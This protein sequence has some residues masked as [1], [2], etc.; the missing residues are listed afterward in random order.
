MINI[1]VTLEHFLRKKMFVCFVCT[2]L[3][4]G[5]TKINYFFHTLGL[6]TLWYRW[7]KLLPQEPSCTVGTRT[8]GQNFSHSVYCSNKY[9]VT[10][11]PAVYLYRYKDEWPDFFVTQYPVTKTP[12]SRDQILY[13]VLYS[14]QYTVKGRVAGISVTQFRSKYTA[15][16]NKF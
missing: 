11:T 14:V 2:Q 16:S 9:P 10:K 12:A 3:Y 7:V 4:N 13:T 1:S 6:Y 8:S 15:K 5:K